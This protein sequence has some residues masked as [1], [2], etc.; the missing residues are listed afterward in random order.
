MILMQQVWK[1]Y[2]PSLEMDQ[3]AWLYSKSMEFV[4]YDKVLFVMFGHVVCK[5]QTNK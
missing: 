5:K 3:I 4:N 1:S 2:K